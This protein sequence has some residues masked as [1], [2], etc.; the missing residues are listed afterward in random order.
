[1]RFGNVILVFATVE[2]LEGHDEM[3]MNTP[4]TR[5]VNEKLFQNRPTRIHNRKTKYGF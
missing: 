3:N 2:S 5:E 1:M 4:T